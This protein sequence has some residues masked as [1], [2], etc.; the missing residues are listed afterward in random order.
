MYRSTRQTVKCGIGKNKGIHTP[1]DFYFKK[2][3]PTENSN[4]D[5]NGTEI[6]NRSKMT[7]ASSIPPKAAKVARHKPCTK[8]TMDLLGQRVTM[9]EIKQRQSLS[10]TKL[11]VAPTGRLCVHCLW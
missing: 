1:K 8:V 11:L 9:K 10:S 4:A 3:S 2:F 5:T 7:H 6:V